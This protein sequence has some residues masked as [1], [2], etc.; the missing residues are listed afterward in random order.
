M[1]TA[2]HE[3]PQHP[4]WAGALRV[5]GALTRS[6]RL[7]P[8]SG[9]RPHLLL[10]VQL[11]PAQGLPYAA[12]VDLGDDLRDHMAAEALLPHMAQ[13]AALSVAGEG[14]DLREEEGGQQVLVLLKA[15]SVVLLQDPVQP[16]QASEPA[17]QPQEA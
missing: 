5:S 16:P 15:H 9:E 12:S 4:T 13:G 14:L 6:A 11:R 10:C 7:I 3:R 17:A 8:T 2:L 1:R